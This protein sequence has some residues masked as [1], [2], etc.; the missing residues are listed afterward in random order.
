MGSSGGWSCQLSGKN[1]DPPTQPIICPIR[2]VFDRGMW[3]E[4]A[5]ASYESWGRSYSPLV[6]PGELAPV[7]QKRRECGPCKCE[8]MEYEK[9]YLIHTLIVTFKVYTLWIKITPS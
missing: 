1:F 5:V 2:S 6:L 9:F 4:A 3:T 8:Y 7:H